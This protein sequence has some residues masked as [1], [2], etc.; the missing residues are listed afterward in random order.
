MTGLRRIVWEHR[1]AVWIIAAGLAI[2]AVVYALVVFPLEQ[3]VSSAEQQAGEATRQLLAAKRA[4]DGARGTV[5]GKE[6]ADQELKK[7][8]GEI[9][10]PDLSGA[11]RML[12]PHLDQLARSTN[13]TTV[14][15]RWEP[16][17]EGSGELRK[18]TMTLILAGEYTNVRRFIHELETAPEFLVLES[19]AVISGEGDR[20]LN[21]TAHVST[22]YRTA[23]HGN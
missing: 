7:F 13:L 22:Y 11:R 9:L 19:V 6:Q 1:R 4:F 10:A 5:T 2:N 23:D 17:D 20:Q 15:Y 14:R 3:R 18:L 12:Y 21:V 16:N 8:Y